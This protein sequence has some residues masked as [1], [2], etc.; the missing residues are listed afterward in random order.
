V[1]S[2]VICNLFLSIAIFLYSFSDFSVPLLFVFHFVPLEQ[3]IETR[4]VDIPLAS[5]DFLYISMTI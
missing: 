2:Q 5:G 3:I 4:P 1:F